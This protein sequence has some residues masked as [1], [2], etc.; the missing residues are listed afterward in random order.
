M[1]W[2][3]LFWQLLPFQIVECQSD[4]H[5]EWLT[6]RLVITLGNLLV[7]AAALPD[8]RNAIADALRTTHTHYPGDVRGIRLL[9]RWMDRRWGHTVDAKGV[10]GL[11]TEDIE[12]SVPE[13]R[14]WNDSVWL[15]LELVCLH[16]VAHEDLVVSTMGSAQVEEWFADGIGCHIKLIDERF[17]ELN[18]PGLIFPEGTHGNTFESVVNEL[19]G[20]PLFVV[21][22]VHGTTL[23][24]GVHFDGVFSYTW[25]IF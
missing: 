3:G 1:H 13:C 20:T 19:A 21:N 23:S 17:Q 15:Q 8:T 7:V 22:V 5:G 25:G 6:D 11:C 14:P 10:S 2:L 24:H 9:L 18:V 4:V 16:S 12:V